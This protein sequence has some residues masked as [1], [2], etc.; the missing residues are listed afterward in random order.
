[1]ARA[2]LRS[3]SSTCPDGV[4]RAAG[5]GHRSRGDVSRH[6][7]DLRNFPPQTRYMRG[8]RGGRCNIA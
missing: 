5:A 7:K 2:P 8:A 1:V 6:R 4:L 3:P